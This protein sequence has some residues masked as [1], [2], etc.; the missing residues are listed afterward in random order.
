[1]IRWDLIFLPFSHVTWPVIPH[2]QIEKC[3][4]HITHCQSYLTLMHVTFVFLPLITWT[5]SIISHDMDM[6]KRV[7]WCLIYYD[8]II[9]VRWVSCKIFFPNMSW[10]TYMIH[11]ILKY[12]CS[13]W[14]NHNMI[15][16]WNNDST[17]LINMRWT[18]TYNQQ[19]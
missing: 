10:K 5:L 11:F 19:N 4:M 15:T 9:D 14:I 1:M 12:A 7:T 16:F 17:W 6:L 2:D 8:L 18:C 3:N 13:I